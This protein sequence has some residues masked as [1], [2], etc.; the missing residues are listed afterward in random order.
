MTRFA[1]KTKIYN[2][3]VRSTF[4]FTA[5]LIVGYPSTAPSLVVG[6]SKCRRECPGILILYSAHTKNQCYNT[7]KIGHLK[8]Y[9]ICISLDQVN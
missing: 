8:G 3:E 9:K 1:T 4:L 6:T 7:L 5:S 2:I